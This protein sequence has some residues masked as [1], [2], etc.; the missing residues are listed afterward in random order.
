MRMSERVNRRPSPTPSPSQREEQL[1]ASAL[2]KAESERAAFLERAC[3]GNAAL[4]RRLKALLAAHARPDPRLAVPEDAA[5]LSHRRHLAGDA[6]DDAVGLSFGRYK[7]L[8]RL[9]E[10][11]WGVVYV[12]QQTEPV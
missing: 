4:H 1:F 11:G 12:A 6:T 10:G 5:L 9:G 3:Q 8:E 2:D 7:I